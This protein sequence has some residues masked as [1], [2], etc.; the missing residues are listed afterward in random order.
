MTDNSRKIVI[1]Y[2]KDFIYLF[3]FMIFYLAPLRQDLALYWKTSYRLMM[4]EHLLT[5]I[6]TL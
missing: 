2:T 5:Y 4:R 1:G 3:I 6:F